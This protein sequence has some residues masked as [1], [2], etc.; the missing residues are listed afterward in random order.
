MILVGCDVHTRIQQIA[1]VHFATG[2]LI[3]RRL[4]YENGEAEK[5][6]LAQH[7]FLKA[8]AK[9]HSLHCQYDL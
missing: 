9:M 4:D 2:E 7:A 8:G 1:L 5:V 3:K 6:S